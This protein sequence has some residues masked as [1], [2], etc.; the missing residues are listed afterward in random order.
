M[1]LKVD[2]KEENN[3]V[4]N[5]MEKLTKE[6]ADLLDNLAIRRYKLNT[7]WLTKEEGSNIAQK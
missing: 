1:Q 4:N 5:K 7:V 3:Y 6:M 2:P